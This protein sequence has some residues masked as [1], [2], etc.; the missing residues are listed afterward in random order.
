MS[1]VEPVMASPLVPVL[2]H[3]GSGASLRQSV[4]RDTCA[5]DPAAEWHHA[6]LRTLEADQDAL[7]EFFELAITWHELDYSE[8][9]VIPPDQWMTFVENHCWTDR[10]RIERIFRLATDVVAA[11]RRAT[12]EPSTPI[13]PG[14][15]ASQD[16]PSGS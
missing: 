15:P 13:P 4:C 3:V 11:S 14:C 5:F 1:M 7:L 8:A 9:G 6:R 12:R 10:D 16:E 2:E